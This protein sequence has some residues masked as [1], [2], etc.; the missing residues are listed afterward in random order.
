M[1]KKRKNKY[2]GEIIKL[3]ATQALGVIFNLA[4]PFFEASSVYRASARQ[5]RREID[6]DRTN[7]REKI[8]YLKKVGMIESFVENKERYF[9]LTSKAIEA[10][11]CNE[12]QNISISRP[13]IWDKKWRLVIFDIAEEDKAGRNALRNKLKL[14]GF[15]Q[16]QK[17][18]YAY[19]FECSKEI[20]KI[21][22]H[23]N[24]NKYVTII[25]AEI[26]QGEDKIIE[27]FLDDGILSN[28][29]LI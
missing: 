17:S 1:K 25:I 16:I 11:K 14:L 27:Q 19:P 26:I 5:I 4:L 29:D 22:N 21:S 3:K 6:Y 2:A 9:E 15:R 18:V 20:I 12:Y 13:E 24:L 7:I 28:D 8:A 10:I 23:L